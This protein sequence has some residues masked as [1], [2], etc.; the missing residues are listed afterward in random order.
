MKRNSFH[1]K[2]R[3][4]TIFYLS[5]I[6]AAILLVSNF[7]PVDI[8]YSQNISH[9]FVLSGRSA[10]PSRGQVGSCKYSG[11][12]SIEK[13]GKRMPLYSY[14]CGGPF[15]PTSKSGFNLGGSSND[16]I[17]WS[18]GSCG[19][20]SSPTYCTYTSTTINTPMGP[21]TAQWSIQDNAYANWGWCGDSV[22]YQ[23]VMVVGT[24]SDNY[25]N[26]WGLEWFTY[27]WFCISSSQYSTYTLPYVSGVNLNQGAQVE[28]FYGTDS[29]GNIWA[30]LWV[31]CINGGTY[32]YS[33]Q[34]P[35]GSPKTA[36]DGWELNLVCSNGGCSTTFTSGGGT[37][38]YSQPNI[39]INGPNQGSYTGESSNCAY[40]SVSVVGGGGD[41]TF[42]C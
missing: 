38:Q 39:K 24:S 30:Y 33:S 36:I 18:S 37:I 12:S 5:L 20:S 25:L 1:I 13:N 11:S 28:Q 17:G 34:M 4:S 6:A 29:S 21:N 7:I 23:N 15:N 16:E 14:I 9:G 27:G 3:T 10:E 32:S 40:S 26:Q 41:Q 22:T 31:C 2:F 8:G 35:S 19:Q 42:A